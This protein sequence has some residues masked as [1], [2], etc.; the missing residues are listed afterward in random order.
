MAWFDHFLKGMHTEVSDWSPV[1]IFV[2]GT[3]E[4]A[5]QLSRTTPS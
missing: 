4:G 1:K 5:T 2:M 3:G